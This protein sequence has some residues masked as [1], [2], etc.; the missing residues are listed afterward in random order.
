MSERVRPPLPWAFTPIAHWVV[1][2]YRQGILSPPTLLTYLGVLRFARLPSRPY[3]TASQEAIADA[4]GQAVRTVRRH[5]RELERAGLLVR[6]HRVTGRGR[7]TSDLV[8]IEM[9]PD[10]AADHR[11]KLAAGSHRTELAA[12]RRAVRVVHRPKLAADHRPKLAAP[13]GDVTDEGDAA[14]AVGTSSS[15]TAEGDRADKLGRWTDSSSRADTD[16]RPVV[17][18]GDS[19]T[20]PD[21]RRWQAIA[22]ANPAAPPFVA[23]DYEDGTPMGN[24]DLTKDGHLPAHLWDT[25]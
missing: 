8:R 9:D 5:L 20:L 12:G 3:T 18:I 7:Q 25:T 11:T 22:K 15:L 19:G 6:E 23:V 13:E 21:G 14:T 10:A 16:G 4:T 2:L 24:Y 1:M 17:K